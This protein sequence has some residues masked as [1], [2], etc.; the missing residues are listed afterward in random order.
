MIRMVSQ[1]GRRFVRPRPGHVS[2]ANVVTKSSLSATGSSQAPRLVRR[3]IVP[4]E[5]AIEQVGQA[6]DEKDDQR[7]AKVA[8]TIRMTKNGISTTRARVS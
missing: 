8:V 1:T 4:G 3:L 5:Q 6:R 2:T 7:P